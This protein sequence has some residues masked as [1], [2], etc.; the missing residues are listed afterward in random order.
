M[1]I[2]VKALDFGVPLNDW[3]AQLGHSNS[4]RTYGSISTSTWS[5]GS[6]RF[7]VEV[8]VSLNSNDAYQTN[9]F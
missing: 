8:N 6:D 9:N 1:Y 3:Q 4:V 5:T 7:G 2:V